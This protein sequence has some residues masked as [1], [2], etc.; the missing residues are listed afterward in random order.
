MDP[1]MVRFNTLD[2]PV[3]FLLKKIWEKKIK[4]FTTLS[5]MESKESLSIESLKY[6]LQ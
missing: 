1:T 2:F 3:L 6:N 5:E 4:M